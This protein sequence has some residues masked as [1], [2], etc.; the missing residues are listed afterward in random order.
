[1]SS[2]TNDTLHRDFKFQPSKKLSRNS[3]KNIAMSSIQRSCSQPYESK[4][5]SQKTQEEKTYRSK[6][7]FHN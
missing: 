6:L 3:V 2:V 1:M 7:I 4:R 5:N